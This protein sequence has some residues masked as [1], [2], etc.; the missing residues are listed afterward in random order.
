MGAVILGRYTRVR[1]RPAA[2]DILAQL[3]VGATSAAAAALLEGAE[4]AWG[5]APD[6]AVL[7]TG[8]NVVRSKAL[9]TNGI[10]FLPTWPE[11]TNPVT[12]PR[13]GQW[14]IAVEHSA[15][16]W[17]AL[18]EVD[19]VK[20]EDILVEWSVVDLPGAGPIALGHLRHTHQPFDLVAPP[21]RGGAIPAQLDAE[22]VLQ[23][24][25]FRPDK[26]LEDRACIGDA[27]RTEHYLDGICCHVKPRYRYGLLVD[28]AMR[29][30]ELRPE[31]K[32]VTAT[33][34]TALFRTRLALFARELA[35]RGIY[36]K[37]D[38]EEVGYELEHAVEDGAVPYSFHESDAALA[39]TVSGEG[40]PEVD[41]WEQARLL[42]DPED[43]WE[44]GQSYAIDYPSMPARID[45]SET[46]LV[47]YTSETT[48]ING[49]AV[50]DVWAEAHLEAAG[51]AAGLNIGA[52]LHP[53]L[54]EAD[55]ER[56]E[57]AT[58]PPPIAWNAVDA[59]DR[60]QR[61]AYALATNGK[62]DPA[63]E[64]NLSRL[65]GPIVQAL[66]GHQA[67]EA[68]KALGQVLANEVTATLPPLAPGPFPGRAQ[69]VIELADALAHEGRRPSLIADALM[70]VDD[71][72]EWRL[73]LLFAERAGGTA[74]V[75]ERSAA[76]RANDKV[77][78]PAR[79]GVDV[80]EALF[81]SLEPPERS[82]TEQRR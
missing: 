74:E 36:Y 81:D 28:G 65:R 6:Q 47:F 51:L 50:D 53:S 33:P 35:A 70:A 75:I 58:E 11:A 22:G 63:I 29:W 20:W 1:W 25:Q 77:F 19:V 40:A 79:W 55:V 64:S 37:D 82:S 15:S 61:A 43:D 3:E 45:V 10:V 9:D 57:G 46:P 12:V 67:L 17:A 32:S 71:P 16:I 23:P 41:K 5:L 59:A 72:M 21:P 54:T 73:A 38:G 52:A 2:P 7:L 14:L 68:A 8:N 18:R 56:L 30:L 62:A 27:D 4:E 31:E 26:D 39:Y 44:T 34:M 60:V 66:L 13:A 48:T 24:A 80:V 76:E 42:Y 49:V 78:D 69:A